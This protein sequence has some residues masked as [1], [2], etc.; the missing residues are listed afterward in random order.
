MAGKSER[1][2]PYKAHGKHS[3]KATGMV[4]GIDVHRDGKTATV[5]V[6]HEPPKPKKPSQG[7]V[8]GLEA[9]QEYPQESRHTMP[10]SIAKRF[11]AG[12]PVSV[13]VGP[14]DEIG[15]SEQEG[16]ETGGGDEGMGDEG[17]E[18]VK[19]SAAKAGAKGP[20][21]A[22][23]NGGKAPAGGKGGKDGSVSGKSTK[24]GGY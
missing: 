21:Q 19:S 2:A 16:D 15:D 24:K 23:G 10:A 18:D 6:R 8:F 13:H 12:T 7:G 5:T 17:D 4:S 9:G 3:A 11:P 1:Y 14:D 22:K 20:T